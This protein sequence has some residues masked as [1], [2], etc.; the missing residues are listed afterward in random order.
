MVLCYKFYDFC[1]N[2]YID[3]VWFVSVCECKEVK[4]ECFFENNVGF[5]NV[6]LIGDF[7]CI[8]YNLIYR[9]LK[10]GY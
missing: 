4:M 6:V 2:V 8:Y 5:R 7:I 10:L 9:I 3:F 1:F